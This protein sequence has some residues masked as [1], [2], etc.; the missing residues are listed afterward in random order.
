[1]LDLAL[2]LQLLKRAELI[3]GWNLVIN[4]M[5]LENVNSFEAQAAQTSF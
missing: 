4:T 1:V 5:E 2:L 3:L